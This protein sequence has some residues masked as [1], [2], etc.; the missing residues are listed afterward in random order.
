[1]SK[2]KAFLTESW[3]KSDW[4]NIVFLSIFGLFFVVFGAVCGQIFLPDTPVYLN[5]GFYEQVI[6]GDFEEAE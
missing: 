2:I 4:K 5:D 3:K 6:E 1:M